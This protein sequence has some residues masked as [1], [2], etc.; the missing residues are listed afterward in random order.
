MRKNDFSPYS[1][2]AACTAYR[3]SF[4]G[5]PPRLVAGTALAVIG[6]L[7]GISAH[8]LSYDTHIA[9][10]RLRGIMEKIEGDP[11]RRAKRSKEI[12]QVDCDIWKRL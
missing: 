4:L 2:P 8:F 6:F 3:R 10:R 11:A 7:G 1:T 5:I 9:L 12:P